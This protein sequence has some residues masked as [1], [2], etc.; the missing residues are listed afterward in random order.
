MPCWRRL[1]EWTEADVWPRLHEALLAELRGASTL[2]FSR[3]AVDGSR[4][5]A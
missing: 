3:A 4:I 5:R 1:P 2:D